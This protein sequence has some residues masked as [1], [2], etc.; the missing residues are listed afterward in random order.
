M[1]SHGDE[2]RN[3]TNAK[4]TFKERC[5]NFDKLI[6]SCGVGEKREGSPVKRKK[7]KRKKK[8]QGR[9][10]NERSTSGNGNIRRGVKRLRKKKRR[11]GYVTTKE[12]LTAHTTIYPPDVSQ[13]ERSTGRRNSSLGSPYSDD[14][15]RNAR[16]SANIAFSVKVL[17]FC[18]DG[19]SPSITATRRR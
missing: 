11:Y 6:D 10:G 7:E 3:E 5:R 15:S 14:F 17:A 2:T 16:M 12:T 13:R 4:E 19:D 9:G 1:Y 18:P 8:K